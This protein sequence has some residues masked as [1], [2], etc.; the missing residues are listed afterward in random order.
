MY[1]STS[2][3]FRGEIASLGQPNNGVHGDEMPTRFNKWLL[4]TELM[5]NSYDR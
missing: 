2:F 4:D 1:L 5:V 3:I